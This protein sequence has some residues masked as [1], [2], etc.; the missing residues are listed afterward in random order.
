MGT[1][2]SGTGLSIF[3]AIGGMVVHVTW[4]DL[5]VSDISPKFSLGIASCKPQGDDSGVDGQ[6]S[7]QSDGVI[8]LARSESAI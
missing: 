3:S 8:V 5:L 2:A 7:V 4:L 1:N 6:L